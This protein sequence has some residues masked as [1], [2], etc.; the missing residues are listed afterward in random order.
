MRG[1]WSDVVMRSTTVFNLSTV[2]ASRGIRHALV[3][4]RAPGSRHAASPGLTRTGVSIILASDADIEDRYQRE[5]DHA[6][7]PD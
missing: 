4:E 2:I 7:S 6:A 3:P 5:D 1:S